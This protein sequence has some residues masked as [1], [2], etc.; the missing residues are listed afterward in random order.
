MYHSFIVHKQNLEKAEFSS[1]IGHHQ[2]VD[3]YYKFQK[4]DN[5]INPLQNLNIADILSS[6]MFDFANADEDPEGQP[7]KKEDPPCLPINYLGWAYLNK[8][9]PTR[10]IKNGSDSRT[11]HECIRK[12]ISTI[13]YAYNQYKLPVRCKVKVTTI[14]LRMPSSKNVEGITK[15][16]FNFT[17]K[18]AVN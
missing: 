13:V 7:I 4:F 5:A 2:G 6:D 15:R 10:F 12:N 11:T 9:N 3:F 17:Y 16:A 1:L 8:N 14:N 18:N